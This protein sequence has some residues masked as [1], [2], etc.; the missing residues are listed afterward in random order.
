MGFFNHYFHATKQGNKMLKNQN[1]II[2]QK[3]YDSTLRYEDILKLA[4]MDIIR[5]QDLIAVSKSISRYFRENIHPSECGLKLVLS[6]PNCEKSIL[7][8]NNHIAFGIQLKHFTGS[9]ISSK[10]KRIIDSKA[11]LK[12]LKETFDVYKEVY[13]FSKSNVTYITDFAVKKFE[14]KKLLREKFLK[15]SIYIS[16][17]GQF[18]SAE[19][20]T[21]NQKVKAKEF[22]GTCK[23]LEEL[24]IGTNKYWLSA[25]ITCPPIFHINPVSQNYCWDGVLTPRHANEFQNKIWDDTLRQLSKKDISPIGHWVKEVNKSSAIHRHVLLYGSLSEIEEIKSWLS[26]YTKS[27]YKSFN[28]KFTDGKSIRF[29]VGHWSEIHTTGTKKNSVITNYL[30]KTI[31]FCLNSEKHYSSINKQKLDAE[32]VAK[33]DAHAEKFKYRRFGFIGLKQRLT[34]W[35]QLQFFAKKVEEKNELNFPSP[36]R[37]LIEFA[38]NN[39]FSKFLCS[40]F[41]NEISLIYKSKDE[42]FVDNKTKYGE[43]IK[44]ILGFRFREKNYYTKARY[45]SALDQVLTLFRLNVFFTI[46]NHSNTAHTGI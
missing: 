1:D 24:A 42:C 21:T 34:L 38:N 18:Y 11:V 22:H 23:Q 17:T 27:A 16:D 32:I 26:H 36:L 20:L 4:P 14:E 33:A 30:N 15:N 28:S 3:I 44:K 13:F 46:T 40:P 2:I 12:K 8:L 5:C 10:I 43:K 9:T 39:Q 25:T 6:L 29:E 41:T 31:L 37:N 35:K 45:L 7:K 19:S